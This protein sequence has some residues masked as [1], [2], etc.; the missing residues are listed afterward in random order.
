MGEELGD[1][2]GKGNA[3]MRLEW[4]PEAAGDVQHIRTYIEARNPNAAREVVL[5]IFQYTE[6]L[7]QFPSKGRVGRIYNTREMILP[8]VPYIVVYRAKREV[9]EVLRVIHTSRKWP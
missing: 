8:D 9:V 1:R 3:E 4:T 5:Q 7:L 2:R 6:T